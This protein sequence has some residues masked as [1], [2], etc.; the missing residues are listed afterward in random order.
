MALLQ[1]MTAALMMTVK[2]LCHLLQH[3]HRNPTCEVAPVG[4]FRI[5]F[6]VKAGFYNNTPA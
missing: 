2:L 1:V 3:K 5:M 4:A 6:G